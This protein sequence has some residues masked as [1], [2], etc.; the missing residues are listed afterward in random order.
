MTET[1]PLAMNR[2]PTTKST[3]DTK[4]EGRVGVQ[5]I[6]LL[7]DLRAFV[8]ESSAVHRPNERTAT[9]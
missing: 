3:K 7:R 8:V 5:T 6:V 4:T 1:L 9:R 2:N